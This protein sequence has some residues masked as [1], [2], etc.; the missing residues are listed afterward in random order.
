MKVTIFTGDN[1]RHLGLVNSL[2]QVAE[3]VHAVI[4]VSKSSTAAETDLLK[5]TSPIARY[6]NFVRN[7][8]NS[9]FADSTK[10]TK[11]VATTECNSSDLN[12]LSQSDLA[13][14]LDADFFLVFG[15]SFIRGWL[16]D[17]L[18]SK[19]AVNLHM[20]LSPFYRGS[21][22][23]FWAIHDKNPNY[24]GATLHLLSKNLDSGPILFHS[25]PEY[26][27]EDA[28]HFTMK[29]VAKAHKDLVANFRTISKNLIQPEFQDPSMEIRYSRVADFTD[30]VAHDFLESDFGSGAIKKMLLETEKPQLLHSRRDSS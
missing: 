3:Q 14:A 7:A 25:T 13:A 17:F 28:F 20:G 10:T 27:N 18:V 9:Y 15:S 16:C 2:T 6:M 21:A 12:L 24:V 5:A 11:G 30:E 22:C 8:E 23:N 26:Q 29:A 1:K 19:S 4:E